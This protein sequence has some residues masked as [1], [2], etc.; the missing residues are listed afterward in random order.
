MVYKDKDYMKKYREKNKV[1][2]AKDKKEWQR[3]NRQRVR[4]W[5]RRHYN[6]QPRQTYLN[7]EEHCKFARES[8]IETVREW[9][10]CAKRGF[11]P[12]EIVHTPHEHFDKNRYEKAH[13]AY[14]SSRKSSVRD[15]TYDVESHIEYIKNRK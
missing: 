2:L 8:G 5:Q 3:K 13:T 7:F 15:Q 14:M 12:D 9:N 6:Y 4:E 11:F 1:K 10:E